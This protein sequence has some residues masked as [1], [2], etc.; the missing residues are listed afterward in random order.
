MSEFDLHSNIES[1]Q[2]MRS[3]NLNSNGTTPGEIIDTK[4]FE[5]LEYVVYSADTSNGEHEILLEEGDEA[6]FSDAVTLDSNL[7]L[8]SLDG[9]VP[10]DIRRAIH[11][12]SI[13]KKRYQRLSLITTNAMSPN[14][15]SAFAILGYPHFSPVA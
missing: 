7:T 13:G 12:G 5:A 6:N 2:A 11:V 4:G 8:G 15:M 1:R 10:G 9:F 14:F 3:E